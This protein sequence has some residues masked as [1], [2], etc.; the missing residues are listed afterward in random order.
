MESFV[1]VVRN[2]FE[3]LGSC[4]PT[5]APSI[6][7]DARINQITREK[8][9]AVVARTKGTDYCNLKAHRPT[10]RICVNRPIAYLPVHHSAPI[11]GSLYLLVISR[12]RSCGLGPP[13]DARFFFAAGDTFAA[14]VTFSCGSSNSIQQHST[15]P[16]KPWIRRTH[17]CHGHSSST[18]SRAVVGGKHTVPVAPLAHMK[19]STILTLSPT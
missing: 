17:P 4:A 7:G 16:R 2:W 5:S 8:F 19:D 10:P 13:V 1:F 15:I 9:F 6:T 3:I 14:F 18:S 12:R 11:C